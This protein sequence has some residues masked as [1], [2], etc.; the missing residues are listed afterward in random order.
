MLGM[1]DARSLGIKSKESPMSQRTVLKIF[2][3]CSL[4]LLVVS[5]AYSQNS[6]APQSQQNQPTKT[7]PSPS[8]N[9]PSNQQNPPTKTTPSPSPTAPSNRPGPS[10]TSTSDNSSFLDQ[11]IEINQ[12]EVELGRLASTK[13]T[14]KRVKDF[15]AMMVKDHSAGLKKLQNVPGGKNSSAKLSSEHEMLKTRLSGL[16]GMHFDREY[17]DAMVTGHRAAVDLFEKHAGSSPATSTT[18][19]KDTSSNHGASDTGG[20]STSTSKSG[21]STAKTNST[22][23]ASSDTQVDNVAREL[24]PTIKKHLT[25]AENIQKGLSQPAK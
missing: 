12:A 8:T 25:E 18:E 19:P 6:P 14:D 10:I 1:T 5:F 3:S 17:I 24:L 23:H 21:G 7:T 2:A 13:A 9:S 20:A 11:A 16:S 15:A 22:S 4:I